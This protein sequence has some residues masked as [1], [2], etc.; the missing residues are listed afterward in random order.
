MKRS[1]NKYD[2]IPLVST[3]KNESQVNILDLIPSLVAHVDKDLC[4][5]YINRPYAHW[6]GV[7]AD[8]VIGKTVSSVLGNEG[9]LDIKPH[10]DAAFAGKSARFENKM[11]NAKGLRFFDTCLTPI[12]DQNKTIGG[13]TIHSTDV[14]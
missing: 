9:F 6:L 4:Y 5:R 12:V 13:F 3:G 2:G 10:I 11:R 14:T 7:H 8:S 1:Q